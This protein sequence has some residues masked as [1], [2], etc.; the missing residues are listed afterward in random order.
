LI[1]I[2]ALPWAE[3]SLPLS[4]GRPTGGRANG[5]SPYHFAAP[6]ARDRDTEDALHRSLIAGAD[7]CLAHHLPWGLR[8]PLGANGETFLDVTQYR[9][10]NIFVGTT[11]AHSVIFY[12]GKW[13]PNTCAASF[14]WVPDLKIHTFDIV[15]PQIALFLSSPFDKTTPAEKIEL[16]LYLTS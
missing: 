3:G 10:A 2:N 6:S 1:H 11:K 4:V 14:E 15:G 13:S 12:I 5:Y 7:G 9:K 16:W 8:V